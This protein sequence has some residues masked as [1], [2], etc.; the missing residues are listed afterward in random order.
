M[1]QAEGALQAAQAQATPLRVGVYPNAPKVFVDA[2]GKASGILV[3]LLREMASAEH[4]PLEFVACEWQACLH[5]LEAGQIDLLPDVAWSEERARSYAF[6]QVPALHSWSQIYAQR[7]HKIRTLL[8]LKGRRIAVLA[9]SIQAQILPNVLA[10]YGAVLVPSSSLERAFTLVADGQADAVAASHY[11]GDAVAGLHNLEATPVVFN[12]ARLHYAAMPGRQQAVLDAIDRRLTAWRA[13]PNSVYFSTLR[14]WQTGG[15]APAVPTSLLWALAAT[16]GL[17]LSALAVASW[18]RTEVAVRT[19]ELRDN[20]RKLAT[21]LDS[22]DSL[23]YIKDA[24]S[25]Y[26]YVNG[27]MCRLLNRPASAIVGQTDELLFGLEKA[28]MTRAGDL[29]VI[30]EHQRFVTEEHLLG[31]V[32]LTTKIP[33]VR[34]EEVHELCGI[35]TDITPHKQAEESLR[36]AATVFQSG[37][38]MCVLSPDAVM[39][40][41]NQAWGVL[42]GQPADT[43]PGTPFP[44]F[45]IEQDGEDGRERMWNSVR[46]AQSW[47]GEVWMSRH[48]GTRYPAWLTVSAVRDADGLLTNFVCTQSD[49]SARKQADERIVQLAYYDSL[50]GLPNRRLLYD[51]I[52]HCLGLHGRTGRTGALLFLDMDNFK[53]LNDSRGHAVGDELLQEVAARLLACT[54]DTDT[55]ARLGG[56]EFVILL[57]SS[58]VDGQE[59]Q[60]HAETVGEKILAALRE[61]FEVGGAVHH[62]SCSIGV[63]LCIGQKDELDDLMRRGDLAM[64]EA[65]RQGRNTLR[66]FHPSMESEVTYRTEIETELRAALLHSQFVLHYQGQVDGD[67]ILTGAEALVR[68]QHPTRGLVGPAGFIGIAEASGLIVPLGRW[69]LR[70]AC[71]QLALWAQSPATAHFTLAVN[72][73]VRQFLQA[74]F[75]EETLAIVQASGANPARLKLE[76]T[77]TLM[78]EGVEE[79]IGKMRALREHGICFSLDDFGTGYSSLSYLKRLPLDQLKIDQSFVRDVLIDPNDASIARSVVALGKSLGLKIIAEGVETEAQRTFLAGIGC[80]HWQG[81]LFSRPVDART[82]EELAA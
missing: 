35:T 42:C 57:E 71:D 18:L 74:D 25:R 4:W 52:G 15:P 75:V 10:G 41:A 21:I 67:G 6:H 13:D 24:Q 36:I 69:V 80:D 7:G 17:L 23:I 5:A 47:Q 62:A 64:Y 38:G 48:D 82:L 58:G 16:V 19:R 77:E 43:L 11:F 53:D 3:D 73:S 1:A 72:V 32:Y 66:F 49:I 12:P 76:L 39:I 44:R 14:R 45:S 28:K 37:E 65:K 51:R 61:P 81:F 20:E 59:A 60:Q 31:K 29:A 63:T 8:D 26:Q 2:D 33:L 30:E 70:T 46:E 68:W 9:G 55:V 22:V 40:E 79:T 56:D 27:A 34:G 50:T 54:R 78:I